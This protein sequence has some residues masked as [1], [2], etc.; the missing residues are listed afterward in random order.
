MEYNIKKERIGNDLR[1]RVHLKEGDV[2]I[3]WR[4]VTDIRAWLYADR[5]KVMSGKFAVAIDADDPS[6]LILSYINQP[7]YLGINRVV[8]RCTVNGLDSTYDGVAVEFVSRSAEVGEESIMTPDTDVYIEVSGT[9]SGIISEIL[10]ACV[11]ATDRAN[12]AAVTSEADHFV[13]VDDHALAE[14]DHARAESDHTRASSDHAVATSDH[15]TATADHTRAEADHTRAGYDHDLAMEDH[16]KAAEDHTTAEADHTRAEGDHLTASVDHGTAASDHVVASADHTTAT[17]DHETAQTD[18][19]T[20]VEDHA[21]MEGYA[22]AEAGRV[23][24]ESGRVAAE[25]Q[26]ASDFTAAQNQRAQTFQQSEQQRASA[27]STA[28]NERAAQFAASEAERDETFASKEATRDAANEA[29]LNAAEELARLASKKISYDNT[30]NPVYAWEQG[31]IRPTG[32]ESTNLRIRTRDYIS[33]M[34]NAMLRFDVADGYKY[35]IVRYNASKEIIELTAWSTAASEMVIND[36]YFRL[37]LAKVDDSAIEPSAYTNLVVTLKIQEGEANL[38]SHNIPFELWHYGSITQGHFPHTNNDGTKA[39]IRT[40][41]FALP[42]YAKVVCNNNSY[43]FNLYHEND[44]VNN[45]DTLIK[46]VGI[47][48]NVRI[49]AYKSDNTDISASEYY[50]IIKSIYVVTDEPSIYVPSRRALSE[51]DFMLGSLVGSSYIPNASRDSAFSVEIKTQSDSVISCGEAYEMVW[52]GEDY[53]SWRKEIYLQKGQV[54]RLLFRVV[55]LK[56][57]NTADFAVFLQGLTIT[58]KDTNDLVVFKN[59]LKYG[60][61][62]GSLQG[63]QYPYTPLSTDLRI[64]SP[65][66]HLLKGTTITCDES[67]D[68]VLCGTHDYVGWTNKMYVPTTQSAQLLMRKH[69]NSTISEA[70]IITMVASLNVSIMENETQ[71]P[72]YLSAI[73]NVSGKITD[74]NADER[75]SYAFITDLHYDWQTTQPAA[76]RRQL[77]AFV[78]VVNGS[79]IDLAVVGGDVIMGQ[80]ATKEAATKLFRE[81]TSIL[82]KCT[83]PIFMVKGN[84][85]YNSFQNDNNEVLLDSVVSGNFIG[86]FPTKP[87]R[88]SQDEGSTY[89][90]YDIV[91]KKTRCIFLDTSD[92]HD[93]FNL[94]RGAGQSYIG[95]SQAQLEWFA[96]EALTKNEGWRYLVFCHAPTIADYECWQLSPINNGVINGIIKALNERGTYSGSGITK[97]FTNATSKVVLIHHGH[98]HAD[99]IDYNATYDVVDICTRTA[100]TYSRDY[101]LSEL[102]IDNQNYIPPTAG[103]IGSVSES[104]FDVVSVTSENIHAYRFGNGEDKDIDLFKV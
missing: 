34:A 64:V 61:K 39:R 27:F 80:S 57:I 48:Q 40:S 14:S 13:F 36:P 69:D 16:G 9:S 67:Y 79:D 91:G 56:E 33:T 63:S 2:A 8:V 78:D 72:E 49:V 58:T 43:K 42:R 92:W 68:I 45:I 19:A 53:H 29:A 74:S 25:S 73:D 38:S 81:M 96:N 15:S 32:D 85:D 28:Q 3:D 70:D 71:L 7:E 94:V 66:Y 12:A 76:T 1:L 24:A 41:V 82:A 87:I 18:H 55:P 84:H 26:R 98:T 31:N 89:F 99:I 95:I 86:V 59:D 47:E 11:A 54:G 101:T 90:Y 17:N 103:V 104:A 50:D 93:D 20:A 83:K 44:F 51:S 30:I 100:C 23:A 46:R 102:H 60:W 21:K 5:Q 4:S 88:D 65:S 52:A 77:E 62:L 97:D 10:A 75:V 35:I 22:T 37:L 6:V